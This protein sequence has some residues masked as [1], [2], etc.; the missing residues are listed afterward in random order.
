MKVKVTVERICEF[1][2]LTKDAKSTAIQNIRESNNW[3]WEAFPNDDEYTD[4]ISDAGF[5]EPEISW[6][7][8]WSQGDGYSFTSGLDFDK[9]ERRPDFQGVLNKVKHGKLIWKVLQ[10]DFEGK[11]KRINHHYCHS[12]TCKVEID[13]PQVGSAVYPR[14]YEEVGALTSYLEEWIDGI[15]VELCRALYHDLEKSH[16]AFYEEA[17][18]AEMCEVNEI[19]FTECG[20]ILECDDAVETSYASASEVELAIKKAIAK[21]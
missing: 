17:H 5:S 4:R 3:S 1:G 6:S 7:G 21:A 12:Y 10:S 20:E 9:F 13:E 11:V 15:R 2:E 14:L 18:V 16:D 8:F 19:Y